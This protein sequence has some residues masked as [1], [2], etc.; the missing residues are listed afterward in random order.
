M[1]PRAPFA[2]PDPNPA[3][4]RFTRLHG[5]DQP[6]QFPAL[7]AALADDDAFVRSAAIKALSRPVFRTAVTAELAN[8]DAQI[9]LGALLALRRAGVP[10]PAAL[11]KARLADADPTV[12]QMALMWCGERLLTALRPEIEA[13]IHHPAATPRL[14]ETWLATLD[15]LDSD[16]AKLHAAHS[17]GMRIKRSIPA[18]MIE[19]IVQD[20]GSP[21]ALRALALPRL[22]DPESPRNH[23]LLVRLAEQAAPALQ[24][25]ALRQ[26]S[27]SAHAD[28]PAVLRRLA[29]DRT[30]A[31]QVRAEALQSLAGRADASLA[32]LLDDP[33]AAVRTQ[34]ART[35]R[36]IGGDAA[37][38]EKISARLGSTLRADST[39]DWQ[40]LLAAG[41]DPEAGR[42]VF[43]S[44]GSTCAS[45][46]RIEARGGRIGPDL[47][48][49]GRVA[50]RSQLIR[51]IVQPSDDIAPQFQGWEVRKTNGEIIT[52][53]QGHL[54]SGGA[55]SIISL[56]GREL[57]IPGKE[58]AAFG[59]MTASLM[60]AGLQT[61]LSTEELR[62]LLA[63]LESLR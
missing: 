60:P 28:T 46:H 13:A 34:A 41:G 12:R 59:A 24:V 16:A 36:I 52:G 42:R 48:I 61:L 25:E 35:L 40:Q 17:P 57:V 50:N 5:A 39:E 38:R 45:C 49:V 32:P 31:P 3:F 55:V 26:L 23:A 54:R 1:T 2:P 15:L 7:R 58:V 43:F 22:A 21:A 19:R 37:L 30:L 47:S 10:D 62:D 11:L 44:P 18:V 8:V 14:F 4:A 56:D 9:R 53:L 6:D 63:F 33:A 51:S 29:L 20:E 27:T